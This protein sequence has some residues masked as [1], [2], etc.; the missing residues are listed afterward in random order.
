MSAG[1]KTHVFSGFDK[2][3]DHPVE[4]RV[5]LQAL[6]YPVFDVSALFMGEC[7]QV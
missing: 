2:S 7:A 1:I 6:P 3:I 4:W 5:R